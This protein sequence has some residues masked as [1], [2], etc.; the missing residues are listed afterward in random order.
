[1]K[2]RRFFFL[3]YASAETG[4]RHFESTKTG[5]SGIIVAGGGP[6]EIVEGGGLL[7]A[8][9]RERELEQ[10]IH[11][12]ETSQFAAARADPISSNCR[13]RSREEPREPICVVFSW[14]LLTFR[15]NNE[16]GSIHFL[17]HDGACLKKK[18]KKKQDINQDCEWSLTFENLFR[19]YTESRFC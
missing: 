18:R 13:R 4:V 7:D 5:P 1:M 8:Q 16:I 9:L 11:F 14:I 10:N 6:E 12:R 2:R 19:D 15:G 3:L 17:T